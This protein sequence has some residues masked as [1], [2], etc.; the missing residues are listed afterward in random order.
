MLRGFKVSFPLI[1]NISILFVSISSVKV[2][3]CLNYD[4]QHN[5]L[6]YYR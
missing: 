6:G 2:V 3:S 5:A 4:I 1:P